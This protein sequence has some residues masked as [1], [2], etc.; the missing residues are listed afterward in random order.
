MSRKAADRMNGLIDW[1]A[2]VLVD[3]PGATRVHPVSCARHYC[4]NCRRLR[5]KGHCPG[6]ALIGS[7]RKREGM[8]MEHTERHPLDDAMRKRPVP[9]LPRTHENSERLDH[10]L[11]EMVRTYA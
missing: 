4:G 1:L 5:N 8:K 9:V 3:V 11:R 10:Y 2:A 7:A 6:A